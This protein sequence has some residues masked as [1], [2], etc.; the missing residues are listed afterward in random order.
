M[1]Q[2]DSGVR[3]DLKKSDLDRPIAAASVRLARA[4]NSNA[5]TKRFT[6]DFQQFCVE[7]TTNPLN[8]L[9]IAQNKGAIIQI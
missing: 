8:V 6:D 4:H 1:L 5:V 7:V 9:N 3:Y 2:T